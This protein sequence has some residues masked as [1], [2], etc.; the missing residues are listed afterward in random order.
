MDQLMKMNRKDREALLAT[1]TDRLLG[2]ILQLN[3]EARYHNT[4]DAIRLTSRV[5]ELKEKSA[6]RR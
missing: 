2:R 3:R 4:L 1:A 5:M 6:Q